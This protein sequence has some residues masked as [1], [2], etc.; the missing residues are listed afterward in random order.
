MS[1]EGHADRTFELEEVFLPTSPWGQSMAGRREE[2]R[3]EGREGSAETKVPKEF[4][5]FERKGDQCPSLPLDLSG[6]LVTPPDLANKNPRSNMWDILIPKHD[7]L[8]VRNSKV[9]N[10]LWLIRQAHPQA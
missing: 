6:L 2:G 1:W 9:T 5:V 4:G 3:A 8:V 10:V 7:L